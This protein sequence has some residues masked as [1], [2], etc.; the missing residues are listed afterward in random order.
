MPN[1]N[2][3]PSLTL[4]LGATACLQH[5]GQAAHALSFA[6]RIGSPETQPEP[7]PQPDPEPLTQLLTLPQLLTLALALALALALTLALT[8]DLALSH[9]AFVPAATRAA[10]MDAILGGL[11]PRQHG[12]CQHG[13]CQHGAATVHVGGGNHV[14]VAQVASWL[15]LDP[16]PNLN[17]DSNLQL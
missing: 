12:A 3:N 15:G 13:A 1:P 14:D 7:Q 9:G 17:P 5:V 10:S 6:P 8:L 16:N 4:I 11:A 2:P